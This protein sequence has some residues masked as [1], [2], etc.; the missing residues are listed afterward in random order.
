MSQVTVEETF[1]DG[2]TWGAMAQR[3]IPW[4]GKSFGT[5]ARNQGVECVGGCTNILGGGGSC[6]FSYARQPRLIFSFPGS[7][8]HK[9]TL[10]FLSVA[11]LRMT[12]FG[13]SYGLY[14]MSKT[15]RWIS[16]LFSGHTGLVIMRRADKKLQLSLNVVGEDLMDQEGKELGEAAAGDLRSAIF[17]LHMLD[18][19]GTNIEQ[20]DEIN[21]SELNA[22][23]EKVLALSYKQQSAKDDTKFEINPMDLLTG[24]DLVKKSHFCRL[25]WF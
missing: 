17:S 6:T 11:R 1:E 8:S 21:V 13:L 10:L 25:C 23:A 7:V 4:R 5:M 3:S 9:M 22:M 12:S 18:P 16:R 24:H 15:P 2:E 20:P 19:T 14:F